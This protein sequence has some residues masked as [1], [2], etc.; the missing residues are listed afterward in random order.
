M[1]TFAVAM[2]IVALCTAAKANERVYV[3]YKGVVTVNSG[4]F[5]PFSCQ[6]HQSSLVYRTCYDKKARYLLINLKG[7]YYHYCGIPPR[8][9]ENLRH[10]SSKGRYYLKNIRGD[11]AGY[12]YDCRIKTAAEYDKEG[13]RIDDVYCKLHPARCE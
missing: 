5:G 4:W 6:R 1:R 11:A 12:A 9:V 8:V 2:L 10:A 7:T 3:K 13:V